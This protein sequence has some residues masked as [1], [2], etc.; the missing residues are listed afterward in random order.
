MNA[1]DE[2]F[3][4][5]FTVLDNRRIPPNWVFCTHLQFWLPW[6]ETIPEIPQVVLMLFCTI[7]HVSISTFCVA[8]KRSWR[9]EDVWKFEFCAETTGRI[10]LFFWNGLVS[11]PRIHYVKRARASGSRNKGTFS[12]T[13]P[14]LFQ[15]TIF[16]FSSHRIRRC[17]QQQY[18]VGVPLASCYI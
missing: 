4:R 9:P 2:T 18:S 5:S 8:F 1:G 17:C 16:D 14:H 6:V 10:G 3:I 12:I 7:C 15:T 13:L 11:I